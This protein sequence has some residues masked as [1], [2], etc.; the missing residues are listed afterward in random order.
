LPLGLPIEALK[1]G[2]GWPLAPKSAAMANTVDPM[3]GLPLDAA[4]LGLEGTVEV[5][6]SILIDRFEVAREPG[7]VA[8]NNPLFAVGAGLSSLDGIEFLCE[9]EKQFGVQIKDLDWWV[10]ETPTLL[11]VAQFVI[12][13]TK[14]QHATR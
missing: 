11:G 5:L 7:D 2:L 6:R 14:Q 9:V 4:Q 10:Y 13:L 3:H 12:E 1:K 8:L